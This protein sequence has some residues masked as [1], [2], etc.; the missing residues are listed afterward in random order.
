MCNWCTCNIQNEVT[1]GTELDLNYLVARTGE[2][3]WVVQASLNVWRNACPNQQWL[4]L[5]DVTYE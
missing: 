2:N 1:S 4:L 5:F 3:F